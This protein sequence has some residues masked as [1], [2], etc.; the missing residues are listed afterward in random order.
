M[1]FNISTGCKL[2]DRSNQ[3]TNNLFMESLLFLKVFERFQRSTI[4]NDHWLFASSMIFLS[5][6]INVQIYH[7]I[8]EHLI[9]NLVL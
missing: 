3:L 9:Q 4:I 8:R 1:Y 5:E 6:Y 2:M 7:K